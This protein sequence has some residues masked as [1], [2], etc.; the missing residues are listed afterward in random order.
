MSA[1]GQ[2]R[3]F[4][5]QIVLSLTPFALASARSAGTGKFCSQSGKPI[6]LTVRV[7]ALDEDI[8]TLDITQRIQPLCEGV[9]EVTGSINITCQED[10]N[11]WK[12][13]FRARAEWPRYGRAAKKCNELASPHRRP[14]GLDTRW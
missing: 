4:A 12:T 10:T 13:S 8:F 2:K 6:K 5:P 11:T 7:S 14:R 9:G 3:T 1:L